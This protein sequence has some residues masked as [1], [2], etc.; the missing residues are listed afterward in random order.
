[1]GPQNLN[2]CLGDKFSINFGFGVSCHIPSPQ[3]S[4][5]FFENL[6]AVLPFKCPV[7]NRSLE[8]FTNLGSRDMASQF[9]HHQPSTLPTATI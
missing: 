8:K 9:P 5:I 6:P 7:R 1:M 3:S 2:N 4:F